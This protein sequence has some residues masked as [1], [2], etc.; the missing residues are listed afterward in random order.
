MII[1]SPLIRKLKEDGYYV[2][3]NTSKRGMEVF[4]HCPDVDEF[5]YHE[6]NCVPDDKLQEHWDA[7]VERIKPDYF[8]NLCESI[9]VNLAIHPRDKKRYNMDK[10][11]RIKECNKN[12]YEET[13]KIAKIDSKDYRPYIHFNKIQQKEAKSFIKPDKFNVLVG[14][15]GSGHNK[16]YP[17]LMKIID[18]I[19]ANSNVHVI[20]VGDPRCKDIENGCETEFTKLSGK[21]PMMVSMALTKYA[22]LVIAPDTGLLHASGCFSTPKIGLL[23]HTTKENI[24]KHFKNDYSMEAEVYCAPCMRLIYDYTVQC[25]ISPATGAALCMGDGIHPMMVL[26]QVWKVMANNR[27]LKNVKKVA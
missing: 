10:V 2:I 21:I 8:V 12:Y 22:D 18:S 24:T 1:I 19:N 16:F 6:D 4:E 9:E 13:F 14:L 26:N 23:G 25:P 27:R 5:I 15:M 3:L 20:T 17:W 11:D 7:M